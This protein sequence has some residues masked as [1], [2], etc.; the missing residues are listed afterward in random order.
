MIEQALPESSKKK[1]KELS[2]QEKRN[3]TAGL[4]G[5]KGMVISRPYTLPAWLPDTYIKLMEYQ[6][7]FGTQVGAIVNETIKDF[8]QTHGQDRD[9]DED[10]KE[11]SKDLTEYQR[12]Q[13]ESA[14]LELES[15]T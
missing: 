11:L 15:Y 10:W 4:L 12:T 3:L 6:Y 2:E 5:Y 14:Q 9:D 13:I 7:T 1:W 8:K